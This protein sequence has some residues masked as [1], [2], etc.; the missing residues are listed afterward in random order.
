MS[1]GGIQIVNDRSNDDA[2][3]SLS[4]IM[5]THPIAITFIIIVIKI[6]ILL[7]GV[8]RYRAEVGMDDHLP[9]TH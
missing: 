5:G 9:S 2:F 7:N 4:A 6:I 3:G 1:K 8:N